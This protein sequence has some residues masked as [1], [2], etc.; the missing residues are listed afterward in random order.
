MHTKLMVHDYIR[1]LVE[2]EGC[3]VFTSNG[4]KKENRSASFQLRMHNSSTVA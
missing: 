2:E 3:F 4:Q 1:G